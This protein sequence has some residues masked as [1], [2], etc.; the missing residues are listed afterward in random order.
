M[1]CNQFCYGVADI[2]SGHIGFHGFFERKIRRIDTSHLGETCIEQLLTV[3]NATS[4]QGN[5]HLM[6]RGTLKNTVR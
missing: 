1:I 6:A 2:L 4:D 5:G 3:G